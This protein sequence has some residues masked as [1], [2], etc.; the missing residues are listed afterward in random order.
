MSKEYIRDVQVALDVRK[1]AEL[2]YFDVEFTMYGTAYLVREEMNYRISSNADHIYH[3]IETAGLE[4]IYCA[5]IMT[6]TK[7]YK[8]AS[9]TKEDK[10]TAVKFML[11]K[12]LQQN[13]DIQFFKQ[14]RATVELVR[15]NSAYDVLQEFQEKITG[16]FDENMLYLYSELVKSSYIN[17]QLNRDSYN[18]LIAWCNIEKRNIGEMPKQKDLFEKDIYG[19]AYETE[20]GYQYFENGL[21]ENLYKKKIALLMQGTVCT[22]IFPYKCC[23]NYKYRLVDSR[24]DF[25]KKLT[26]LMNTD[27]FECID[28][29][30]SRKKKMSIENYTILLSECEKSYGIESARTM[31]KYLKQ[32]NVL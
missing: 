1:M 7:K 18:K 24:K 29:I 3:F 9:G 4:D 10:E 28:K 27:I 21:R 14:L 22:P 16:T 30:S 17:L 8:V 15:D 32:W 6:I 2:G 19:I 20:Q 31:E 13:Y 5:N 11:A 26:E 12:Q 23:Y 25:Q